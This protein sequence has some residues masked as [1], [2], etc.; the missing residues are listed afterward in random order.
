MSEALQERVV[1]GARALVANPERWGRADEAR[2]MLHFPCSA[3]SSC[4]R[5]YCAMGALNRATMHLV[6]DRMAAMKLARTTAAD[7][8]APAR[9][10]V[11]INDCYGHRAVVDAFDGVLG[12]D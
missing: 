7:G 2:T 8:T 3:Y 10:L 4:A 12:G 9:E 1:E 5:R 6:H 11:I